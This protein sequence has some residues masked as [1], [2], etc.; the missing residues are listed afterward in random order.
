[1]LWA[2]SFGSE[3]LKSNSKEF[4]HRREFVCSCDE[5]AQGSSGWTQGPKL[6]YRGSVCLQIRD[7]FALGH[8]YLQAGVASAA[9][10]HILSTWQLWQRDFQSES[11][12]RLECSRMLAPTLPGRRVEYARNRRWEGVGV[13]QQR[14]RRR[15]PPGRE[16]GGQGT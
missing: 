16:P 10:A 6:C 15:V 9:L 14:V 4:R 8:L 5:K 7:S 3:G 1:M 12:P 2:T 13:S 11:Q